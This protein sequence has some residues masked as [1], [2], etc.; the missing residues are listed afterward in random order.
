MFLFAM[1]IA[2][3]CT[4]AALLWRAV[5]QYRRYESIGPH[6]GEINLEEPP[7]V[8]VI[9]PARNEAQN[10][11]RCLRGMMAQ[12]YPRE[13]LSIVVVDDHSSDG[14]AGIVLELA[15]ADARVRLVCAG[16]LPAGWTGKAHACWEGSLASDASWL[17]FVDADT[18][19]EPGL[20][21]T[22]IAAAKQ[23]G[24]DMLSLEPFQEL[25]GVWERLIIPAG[26]LL[27]AFTKDLGKVNDPARPEAAANG[28]F[29]LI[30]RGVYEEVGGHAAVRGEICEDSALAR[31]VKH[32]G[33]RM[34][35]MGAERLI[36]TRMYRGLGGLWEGLSKNVTEMIGGG[37][38]T[39]MI[40]AAAVA[41]GC[42][43]VG[44]PAWAWIAA[45]KPAPAPWDRIVAVVATL[46]SGAL[47]GIHVGAARYLRIPMYYGLLFPLGYALGTMIALNGA[48]ARARNKVAW[49][50]RVYEPANTGGVRLGGPVV[51][52]EFNNRSAEADPTGSFDNAG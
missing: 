37:A 13:K 17:C 52:A 14:T 27:L 48:M 2:W 41:L 20:I 31:A 15:A 30:A 19:A 25:G 7:S 10:I 26:F 39:V 23:R 29:I 1:A 38:A 18:C 32:R 6:D 46:T 44:L 8:A 5:G 16:E 33:R 4:V 22:A 45:M 28:Q 47:F 11:G 51:S 21:R 24:L 49:K 34:A 12:D 35:L 43:A 3:A 42:I 50:G 36:R 40:A 9:I